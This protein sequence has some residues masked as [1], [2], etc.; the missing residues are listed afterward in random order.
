MIGAAWWYTY[1]LLCTTYGDEY[2]W[3]AMPRFS[4]TELSA[5][6]VA[7]A[8]SDEVAA[9][10]SDDAD[11]AASSAR[12]VVRHNASSTTAQFNFYDLIEQKKKP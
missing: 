8:A 12:I 9:A 7:A 1:G 3:N 4:F 10:A 2:E 11:L 6:G 5:F